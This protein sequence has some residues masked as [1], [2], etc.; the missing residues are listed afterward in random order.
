MFNVIICEYVE[1]EQEQI[2]ASVIKHKAYHQY[3]W[4][5]TECGHIRKNHASVM[6]PAAFAAHVEFQYEM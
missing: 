5:H 1:K 2:F 3:S 6:K 4:K